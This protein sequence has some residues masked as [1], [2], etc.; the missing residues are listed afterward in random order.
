[1]LLQQVAEDRDHPVGLG[2]RPPAAPRLVH[3]TAARAFEREGSVT[4][5]VG[6]FDEVRLVVLAYGPTLSD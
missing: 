6:H 3:R 4:I 5:V 1:M 2:I